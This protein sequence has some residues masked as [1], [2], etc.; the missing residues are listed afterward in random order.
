MV[1][2]MYLV[3]GQ[4]GAILSIVSA[5]A[6]TRLAPSP[7][8]A[9]HLG[10]GRTFLVNWVLA[11]QQGWRVL[12]RIDDLEGP[13]IKPGADSQA[14]QDLGWLGLDWDEPPA[15]QS[16]RTEA[17]AAALEALIQAGAVYP[18]T[19]TRSEIAL[20]SGGREEPDQ[21]AFYP[22]TCRGR[23]ATPAEAKCA[24]GR[25]A[26]LRFMVLEREICFEDSFLGR[27]CFFGQRDIGDFIVRKSDGEWG[28]QLANVVDDAEAGVTHIVRGE[29]LL[30]SAPRQILIYEALGLQAKR[31]QYT[32]LP[33]VVGPDGRKLGKRHGDTRLSYL[34]EAGVSAGQVRHLL[35]RW[36]GWAPSE[37]ETSLEEW[38]E[39]FVLKHL[40]R[41]RVVYDDDRDRPTP[42]TVR[43]EC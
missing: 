39:R 7:T 22:G 9:L 23:Y 35:A 1:D 14:I 12:L 5:G 4:G 43:G 30:A 40:P 19:C 2:L 28:Y 25:D 29:D 20:A 8:G 36:S 17:Y 41:P 32:H 34:R 31:P 42:V 21:A 6:T 15:W 26:A 38:L 16:R 18:C 24:T 11:R 13:R 3:P 33:L 27:Q 10:N 37:L